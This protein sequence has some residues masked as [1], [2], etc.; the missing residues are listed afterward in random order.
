MMS[1]M[2]KKAI[3]IFFMLIYYFITSDSL[4]MFKLSVFSYINYYLASFKDPVYS[5]SV[6]IHREFLFVVLGDIKAFG[7]ERSNVQVE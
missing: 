7:L 6:C 5:S 1:K 4:F 3:V 2:I